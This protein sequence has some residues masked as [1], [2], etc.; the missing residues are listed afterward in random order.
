MALE[1]PKDVSYLEL[2][3]GDN[4]FPAFS[5]DYDVDD[6]GKS[7][8]LT[9]TLLGY[10]LGTNEIAILLNELSRHMVVSEIHRYINGDTNGCR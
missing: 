9:V 5:P 7:F 10:Q 6:I 1:L 2:D 3:H 4:I 8:D